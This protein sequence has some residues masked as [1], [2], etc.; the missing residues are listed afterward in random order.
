MDIDP[1]KIRNWLWLIGAAITAILTIGAGIAD[2]Q[3]N[4]KK[5]DEGIEKNRKAI[6][7][8]DGKVDTVTLSVNDIAEILRIQEIE[9]KQKADLAAARRKLYRKLCHS[10]TFK[11]ENKVECA[12]AEAGVDR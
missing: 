6:V 7:A 9:R 8:I 12:L 4:D 3:A 11:E 5:H 1:A 2:S 10:L